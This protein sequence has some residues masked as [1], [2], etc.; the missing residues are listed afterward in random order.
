MY[1]S[2]EWIKADWHTLG[3]TLNFSCFW[4]LMR[5]RATELHCQHTLLYRCRQFPEK[6]L[7]I[8]SQ[9]PHVRLHLILECFPLKKKQKTE[10]NK[11]ATWVGCDAAAFKVEN[12]AVRIWQLLSAL[13]GIV[14][15]MLMCCPLTLPS[16]SLPLPARLHPPPCR[17]RG[18]QAVPPFSDWAYVHDD[19][20][21][22]SSRPLWGSQI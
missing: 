8:Q 2:S 1:Y 12:E 5:R 22:F 17:S 4:A 13:E 11:T 15:I 20:W 21:V 16:A 6:T 7:H 14:H 3:Q 19:L 10:T 18:C 9:W